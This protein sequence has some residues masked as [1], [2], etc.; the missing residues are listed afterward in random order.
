MKFLPCPFT[1]WNP[2]VWFCK[3]SHHSL[4]NKKKKRRKD[5]KK[6]SSRWVSLKQATATSKTL[7][8]I[9][10]NVFLRRHIQFIWSPISWEELG[11]DFKLNFHVYLLAGAISVTPLAD[12]SDIIWDTKWMSRSLSGGRNI[13]FF[14]CFFQ[15]S[16]RVSASVVSGT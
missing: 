11:C 13:L 2:R 8:E 15:G 10:Q 3:S 6:K 9:P 5:F 1:S 12:D 14:S 4:S 16:Q 7:K